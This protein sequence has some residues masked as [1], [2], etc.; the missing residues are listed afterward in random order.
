MEICT[1]NRNAHFKLSPRLH[2]QI[3]FNSKGLVPTEQFLKKFFLDPQDFSLLDQ[4]L[5]AFG[6]MNNSY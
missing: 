1:V 5:G 6:F 4:I 3:S 2:F